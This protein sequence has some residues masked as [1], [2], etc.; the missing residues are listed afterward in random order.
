MPQGTAAFGNVPYMEYSLG[1][2]NIL[3][4]LRIDFVRRLTYVD[5]WDKKDCWFFRIDLKFSL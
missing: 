2:E 5:G 1:V 4:F 3:R